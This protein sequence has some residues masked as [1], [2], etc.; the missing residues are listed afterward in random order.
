MDQL[1]THELDRLHAE[2]CAGLAEP[3]RLRL[4]YELADGPRNVTELAARLNLS[5]PLTSRHLKV[6]RERGLVIATRAGAA[7][8]YQLADPRLMDALDILRAI[9]RDALS[10]RAE[11][12][13]AVRTP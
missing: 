6:L 12:V 4:L 3:K 7:V 8:D 9:L 2:L 11:L 10:R 5:Q 1:H 13:G